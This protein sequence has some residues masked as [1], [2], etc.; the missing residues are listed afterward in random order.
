[1]ADISIDLQMKF[2]VFVSV[3]DVSLMV[4]AVGVRCRSVE[5]TVG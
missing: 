3:R 1:M 5:S 4:T 2:N